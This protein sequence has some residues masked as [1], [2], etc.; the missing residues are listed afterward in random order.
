MIGRFWSR[1]RMRRADLSPIFTAEVRA[2]QGL[3]RR[4]HPKMLN[5]GLWGWDRSGLAPTLSPPGLWEMCVKSKFDDFADETDMERVQFA[6]QTEPPK[7]ERIET[8][9]YDEVEAEK[10]DVFLHA[11]FDWP[12]PRKS[13]LVA[14]VRQDIQPGDF[15][16]AARCTHAQFLADLAQVL[17]R[18]EG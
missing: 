4:A 1:N 3:Y 11:E 9:P 2:I 14:Y 15:P 8:E 10:L 13:I 18:V 12:R 17:G 6:P 16:Y 5:W 7:G